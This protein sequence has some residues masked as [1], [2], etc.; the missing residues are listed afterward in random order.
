MIV[1]TRSLH[2]C[3]VRPRA[4]PCQKFSISMLMA[5][6]CVATIKMNINSL[7][8][9]HGSMDIPICKYTWPLSELD[10][11]TVYVLDEWLKLIGLVH[12]SILLCL[13]SFCVRCCPTYFFGRCL[14]MGVTKGVRPHR[15]CLTPRISHLTREPWS[16]HQSDFHQLCTSLM[17]PVCWECLLRLMNNRP[18][19]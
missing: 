8:Y 13:L 1:R 7:M 18:H 6:H 11:E 15:W 17:I 12:V 9:I 10:V 4:T 5:W 19:C 2:S 16:P 3:H 14:S